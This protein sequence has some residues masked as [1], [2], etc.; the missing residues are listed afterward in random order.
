MVRTTIR[1]Y[2]EPAEPIRCCSS[3]MLW[4]SPMLKPVHFRGTLGDRGRVAIPLV[5]AAAGIMACQP[6][7]PP[8]TQEPSEQPAAVDTASVRAAIDS[9]RTAYEQSV[10]SGNF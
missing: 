4:E 6:Q 1:C 9:L 2:A 7:T 10:A 3:C 8:Q 5:V